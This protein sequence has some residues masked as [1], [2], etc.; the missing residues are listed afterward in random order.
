MQASKCSGLLFEVVNDLDKILAVDV[1]TVDAVSV[2]AFQK[3]LARISHASRRLI[4]DQNLEK[5]SSDV[6]TAILD[7]DCPSM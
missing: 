7:K 5:S 3:S 1:V 4:S 6:S 2:V